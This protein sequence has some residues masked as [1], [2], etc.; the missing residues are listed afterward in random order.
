MKISNSGLAT[1][2]ALALLATPAVAQNTEVA[3]DNAIGEVGNAADAVGNSIATGANSVATAADNAVDID[4][5]TDPSLG[6]TADGNLAVDD[7]NMMA[8]D[9]MMDDNMVVTNTTTTSMASTQEGTGNGRWGLL[10]LLGL[11]GFL[12]RPKKGAI[13]LD[14]RDGRG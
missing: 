13:H 6:N 7:A 8:T 2:A 1:M 4:V 10:G 12:F 14:E 9:P 11:A 3:V 5:T